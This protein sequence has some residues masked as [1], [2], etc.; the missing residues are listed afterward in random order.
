[1]EAHL[2]FLTDT[3]NQKFCKSPSNDLFM[4]SL[5]S[6]K[7][8]VSERKKYFHFPKYG[9]MLKPVTLVAILD[10]RLTKK[11]INFLRGPYKE[12]S[13]QRSIPSHMQFQR[14]FL[15]FKPISESIIDHRGHFEFQNETK[16]I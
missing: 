5:G 7:F 6:I 4:Y 14:R 2:G 16:I 8:M 1:M 15:K 13:Y 3:K 11:N 9:P 10:F 12:H